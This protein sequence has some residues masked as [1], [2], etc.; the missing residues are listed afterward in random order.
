MTRLLQQC[1]RA[2]EAE[3]AS[4]A[5]RRVDLGRHEVGVSSGQSSSGVPGRRPQETRGGSNRGEC[6]RLRCLTAT[7]RALLAPISGQ[8]GEE[9]LQ[10]IVE[11]APPRG[12]GRTR[13][14]VALDESAPFGF[15]ER[16]SSPTAASPVRSLNSA[17]A[18][19]SVSRS[20]F[21]MNS[22]G[23]SARATR[24]RSTALPCRGR[25]PCSSPAAPARLAHDAVRKAELAVRA[26]ADAEVV[27]ELPVVQ[28][29]PAA[30]PGAR[31]S[32]GLVVLVAGRAGARSTMRPACRAPRRRP[33]APAD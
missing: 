21:S 31:E 10:Q 1:E 22:N 15:S 23:S 12:V 33:A 11:E 28:V 25:V 24:S 29:V 4:I 27:A 7:R 26:G 9:N 6:T 18:K 2:V 3:R 17:S 19:P 13:V 30:I 16:R 8:I 32:R 20:A 5:E 14:Q